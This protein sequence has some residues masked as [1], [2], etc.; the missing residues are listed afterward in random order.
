MS[1][2]AAIDGSLKVV[3]PNGGEVYNVG[4]TVTIKWNASENI[5]KMMI[6]YSTGPGSLNWIATSI[7]NTGSYSWKVFV[8]NTTNTK[9]QIEIIGYDTGV[10][11]LTDRSDGFFTVNQK[12]NPTPKPTVTPAPTATPK[13][14][15]AP[16]V[17]PT[18]KPTNTIVINQQNTYISITQIIFNEYYYFEGSKTTDL[19]KVDPA[20]V[21]NFTLDRQDLLYLTFVGDADLSSKEVSDAFQNLDEMVYFEE[22]YFY[23]EWEFWVYFETPIEMT[24]Y[25]RDNQISESSNVKLNGKFLNKNDYTLALKDNGEK[26]VT[27]KPEV[28]KQNVKEGEKIEIKVENSLQTNLPKNGFS[29]SIKN[30]FDLSGSVSSQDSHVILTVDGK[31]EVL[32]VNENGDFVKTISLNS[33]SD[34]NIQVSAFDKDSSEPYAIQKA[35]LQFMKHDLITDNSG[36]SLIFWIIGIIC[37]GVFALGGGLGVGWLVFRKR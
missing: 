21:S 32:G 27:I 5:D 19:S 37:T 12:A 13:P 1:P 23:C 22:Y 33:G 29:G 28:I 2:K 11:S 14:T 3:T 16:T 31:E 6:G 7:P 36:S 9:F 20:N 35:T 17:V 24:F 30:S 15:T 25:D 4:D 10:G 26:T 34:T 8:G 18:A